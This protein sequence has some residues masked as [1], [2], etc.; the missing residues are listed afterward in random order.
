M[1]GNLFETGNKNKLF[2]FANELKSTDNPLANHHH[3]LLNLLVYL[4]LIIESVL[5]KQDLDS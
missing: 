2:I 5:P 1:K 4:S 3:Q